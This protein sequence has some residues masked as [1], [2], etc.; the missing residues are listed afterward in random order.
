MKKHLISYLVISSLYF[1]FVVPSEANP[2]IDGVLASKFYRLKAR[3]KLE[4]SQLPEA[5]YQQRTST[6]GVDIFGDPVGETPCGAIDLGNVKNAR[7]Y[8]NQREITIIVSGDIINAN[9]HCK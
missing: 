9:N 3:Q 2:D 8:R 7:G 4:L 6:E 1:S 5:D